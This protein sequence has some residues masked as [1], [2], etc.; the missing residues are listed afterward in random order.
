GDG[1][2]GFSM[3]DDVI[4]P[5]LKSAQSLLAN[6]FTWLL[7]QSLGTTVGTPVPQDNNDDGI[8]FVPTNEPWKGLYHD[9]YIPYI[10]P[11]A[12]V[13]A[14]LGMIVE[15]GIMPWRALR[16]P[17]YSQTRSFVAFILTLV[18]I[19]FTVPM[20]TVMHSFIDILATNVAPSTQEL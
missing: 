17:T 11:L 16:N 3:E 14:L 5:T 19:V 9:Y 15:C 6:G 18:A 7:S 1:L 12:T 20:I 13:L 4:K 2:F 8:V 10:F